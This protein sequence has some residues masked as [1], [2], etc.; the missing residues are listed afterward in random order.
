MHLAR[1]VRETAS[2]K[3][4]LYNCWQLLSDF[5]IFS[6]CQTSNTC[7]HSKRRIKSDFAAALPCKTNTLVGL[8]V[9]VAATLFE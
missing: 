1:R 8:I 7:A 6:A 2:Q 9:D 3:V 5:N 4:C